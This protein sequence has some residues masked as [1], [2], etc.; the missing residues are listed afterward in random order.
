MMEG[1]ETL[2]QQVMVAHFTNATGSTPEQAKHLLQSCRWE[3][4]VC[5][6]P[7]LCIFS[8]T[9]KWGSRGGA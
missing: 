5:L 3:F 1:S 7:P 2:K 9:H 8:R 4:D 6:P